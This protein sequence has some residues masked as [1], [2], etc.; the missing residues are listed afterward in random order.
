MK[1]DDLRFKFYSVMKYNKYRIKLV[2]ITLTLLAWF[3]GALRPRG[4]RGGDIQTICNVKNLVKKRYWTKYTA[5]NTSE[6]V[7]CATHTGLF[8]KI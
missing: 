8:Q 2:N 6:F 3:T 4:V 5:S 7:K 1:E